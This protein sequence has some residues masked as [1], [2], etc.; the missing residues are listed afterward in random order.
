MLMYEHGIEHGS[1]IKFIFI[2]FLP[3]YFDALVDGLQPCIHC[4]M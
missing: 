1:G 4:N 2:C 3:R